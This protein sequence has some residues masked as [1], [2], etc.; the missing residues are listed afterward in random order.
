[1]CHVVPPFM[2]SPDTQAVLIQHEIL[3]GSSSKQASDVSSSSGASS[4]AGAPSSSSPVKKDTGFQPLTPSGER[5]VDEITGLLGGDSLKG[6]GRK[7][8]A[9]LKDKM[10]ADSPPSVPTPPR[11]SELRQ[12]PKSAVG[13]DPKAKYMEK[14]SWLQRQSHTG[15]GSSCATKTCHIL[16]YCFCYTLGGF[17]SMMY[18]DSLKLSCTSSPPVLADPLF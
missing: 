10:G 16:L 17:V 8:M 3:A 5:L 13:S 9:D 11:R 14:A 7:L 15:T 12:Q 2:F 18:S 6:I 4:T 1:M